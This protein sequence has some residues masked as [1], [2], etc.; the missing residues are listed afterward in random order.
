ME[1]IGLAEMIV[2]SAVCALS[3]LPLVAGVV[4]FAV[5]FSRRKKKS[6]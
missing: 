3:V 4:A 5:V 6:S 1:S 2:I